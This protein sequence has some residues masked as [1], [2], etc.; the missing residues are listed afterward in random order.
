L[1]V[2]RKGGLIRL[3]RH[4]AP[5]PPFWAAGTALPYSARRTSPVV[6]DWINLVASRSD[7]EEVEVASAV[8]ETI[9]RSN[10]LRPPLLV[11]ATGPAEAVYARGAEAALAAAEAGLDTLLLVSTEGAIPDRRHDRL[12][13]AIAAWPAETIAGIETLGRLAASHGHGHGVVVP[14]IPPETTELPLLEEIA[15]AAVRGGAQFLAAV[16]ID[17][18]PTAR[19]A[20][21]ERKDVDQET[22]SL[23]FETDLELL[24]VATE[25]HVA[26]LAAERNLADLVPVPGMEPGSNWSVSAALAST[27]NRMI[28][29]NRDVEMGWEMLR[30]SRTIAALGTPIRRIAAA[31]SLAIIEPLEPMIA[32]AVEEWL[33][34]GRSELMDDIDRSWRLRRDHGV[35]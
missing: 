9:Q 19:R 15:D 25:R 2:Y 1:I 28:R 31:A 8:A 29:M 26:A 4:T 20:L 35:A 23:L 17:V 33:A 10:Y 6:V 34:S 14:I 7:Y 16:P 32:E 13:I 11:D 12:T 22:L 5:D 21:A 27:G 24:T 30:A 3:L 18:D